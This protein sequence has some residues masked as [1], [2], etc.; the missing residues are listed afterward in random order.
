MRRP[1]ALVGLLALSSC[2]DNTTPATPD[3][4]RAD[5]VV[6]T[7]AP[8][9]SVA[10]L[11]IRQTTRLPGMDGP[12]DVATDAHGW[13]HIRATTLRDATYVQGYLQARERMAQ[14]DILRRLGSGTLGEAFGV[15]S[16]A[17]IGQDLAFRAIGLR[18][19]AVAMWAQIQTEPSAARTRVALTAFSAGVNQY[20]REIRAGRAE[21]PP[22]TELVLGETTPDWSEVDS[23][24]IGRYQSYS[25]SYSADTEIANSQLIDAV[26]TTFGGADP[27]AAPQRY[28]RR[29]MAQDVLVWRPPSEAAVVP[30]FYPPRSGMAQ[31]FRPTTQRPH[32]AAGLYDRVAP[33]FRHVREGFSVWGDESRGSNNWVV[34]PGMTRSGRALLA[35]DPHLALRAPGHLVGDAPHGHG[36][37]RRG[38]RGGDHLSGRSGRGHRLQPAR[39]LGRHDGL[40]RRH[41]RLPGDHHRGGR[42]SARHGALQRPPGAHPDHHRAGARRRRGQRRGAAGGCSPPRAHRAGD[43]QRAHRE[44][45]GQ[46]GA[47]DPLDGPPGDGRVQHLHGARLCAQRRRGAGRGRGLRGRRAEL[48]LRRHRGATGYASHAV[49]PQR[50]AGALTWRAD[51]PEGT[52][53][54]TVLPGTGEAEWTGTVP[55]AQIPQAVGSATRPYIVTGNNDQVGA[56]RDGNPFDATVY[57]GCGYASGWRA[58]RITQ[59]LQMAGSQMTVEDMQSIQ[60]DHTVL[61][62][63]RFRPFLM[64]AFARLEAEWTTPGTHPDIAALALTLQPRA[65]RLRDAAMRVQSW[66]L[67]G[68]SGVEADATPARRR[69][70]VATSIFHGWMSRLLRGTFSDE[71]A[72][73][74]VGGIDS[75]R[76]ALHLLEHP[77][78]L[79]ARTASGESVLWD[80]LSTADAT[81]TRDVILLRSLDEAMADLERLTTTADVERWLWGSLHT[82]RFTSLIPGTDATLSIPP[83]TDGAFPRGFPRPGGIDVVDASGPGLGGSNY[84][85]GSGASQRLAVELGPDG[86]RAF[87]ALPGGQ[88]IDT[89][90]PHFRDEAELWRT[91]RTHAVPFRE[92]EVVAEASGRWRFEPTP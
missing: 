83:T 56:T 78:E 27:T 75:I 77:T 69:D 60:G 38:R 80:D 24:V 74:R 31:V 65:A 89:G 15:V 45:H 73:L 91:N 54:C 71:T 2:S 49:I 23:L 19:A 43:R 41:G 20:L 26:R 5:A 72:V 16:S 55:S 46:P 18:R 9:G 40:L 6:A 42:R 37:G 28:A 87:N 7:D 85:F 34:T 84:S 25:L 88:S 12:V 76:A 11:P 63:G 57:L 36:W 32:L 47:V 66:T 52:N 4:G 44:A 10:S 48:R 21:A 81:E 13:S 79:R 64:S 92:A 68:A 8:A 58:E 53:P 39:R 30:D 17:A 61:A 67:D 59:R 3:A 51:N 29:A 86:P 22:S 70:A 90:S 33:F 50:A 62:G 35:N 82:V 14:M 1:S